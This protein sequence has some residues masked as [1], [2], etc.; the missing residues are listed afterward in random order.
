MDF[1][2]GSNWKNL[3]ILSDGTIERLRE[4]RIAKATKQYVFDDEG[5]KY[6]D[7]FNGVAHVGHCHPQVRSLTQYIFCT[8]SIPNYQFRASAAP[9][10]RDGAL[11]WQSFFL[12]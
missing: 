9:A 7:C 1:G 3:P 11:L 12:S 5:I 2:S 8:L 6:L 10:C 4:M